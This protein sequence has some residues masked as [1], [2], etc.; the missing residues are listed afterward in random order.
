MN[1][2]L[3]VKPPKDCATSGRPTAAATLKAKSAPATARGSCSSYVPSPRRSMAKLVHASSMATSH[4]GFNF[5][6]AA[7]LTPASALAKP[8]PI[9]GSSKRLR[10]PCAS[11]APRNVLADA[12]VIPGSKRP[13]HCTRVK[14]HCILTH[15]GNFSSVSVPS[16]NMRWN[17]AWATAS[18]LKPPDLFLAAAS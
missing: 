10:T 11:H 13:L 5:S 14:P 16:L 15:C 1:V 4:H 2:P 6:T 17:D 8:I 3:L 7:P 18:A 12:F 9:D